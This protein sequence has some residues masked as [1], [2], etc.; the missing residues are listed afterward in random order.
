MNAII[1]RQEK[2]TS[3]NKRFKLEIIAVLILTLI[4]AMGAVIVISSA[5]QRSRDAR[6]VSDIKRIKA[7][8]E[9]YYSHCNQ[10]PASINGGEPIAQEA[11]VCSGSAVY[12]ESVPEN[13]IPTDHDSCSANDELAKTYTYQ[14]INN[15]AKGSS[16]TLEFCLGN[17]IG[18][19]SAGLQKVSPTSN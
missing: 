9:L 12:L 10:Y 14:V 6:R 11:G 13:P 4:L 19:F 2:F 5:K 17:P 8:L 15:P 7:A 3:G 16:Y 18:E 1:K